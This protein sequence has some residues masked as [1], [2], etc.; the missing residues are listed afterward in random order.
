[1]VSS[2][3][4]PVSNL[5][6]F[7]KI[8]YFSPVETFLPK[9]GDTREER[10]Y[11]EFS[12]SLGLSPC[13]PFSVLCSVQSKRKISIGKNSLGFKEACLSLIQSGWAGEI[14][15]MLVLEPPQVCNPYSQSILLISLF[16]SCFHIIEKFV[17]FV[18]LL[19]T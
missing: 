5:F 19:L 4:L 1:M 6:S 13:V 15:S 10:F 14:S 9:S 16:S 7:Y 2:G 8:T 17:G 18:E 3:F 11:F 12:L